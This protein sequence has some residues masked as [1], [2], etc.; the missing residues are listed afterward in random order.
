[1]TVERIQEKYTVRG[2]LDRI[3]GW[4]NIGMGKQG[5]KENEEMQEI[6]RDPE[7]DRS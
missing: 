1:M 6:Y 3:D 5:E 7:R 4:L 2:T